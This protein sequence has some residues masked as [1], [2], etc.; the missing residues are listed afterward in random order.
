M[1][2]L[3]VDDEKMI[4]E[5]IKYTISTLS[6]EISIIDTASNG[7]EA[8]IKISQEYYDLIFIDIM[9]PKMNGIDML[10]NLNEQAIDSTL[11]VLS[12]HDEFKFAKEAIKYN[13]KE[14]LLKNECSKE[15]IS[16]LIFE[17]HEKL[18]NQQK[19]TSLTQEFLERVIKNNI[20][21]VGTDLINQNFPHCSSKTLFVAVLENKTEK[22]PQ[23]MEYKNVHIESEGLIGNIERVSFYLFSVME[24][25]APKN[26]DYSEILHQHLSVKVACGNLFSNTDK[27]LPECRNSWIG[28]Q[29]LFFTN[30]SHRTGSNRYREFDSE[31]ID[32]MC[33][34]TISD[35]RSYSKEK[36]TEDIK[37]INSFIKRTQPTDTESVVN[38]Y[39]TL[40]S[41]FI[42]YNNKK[43]RNLTEKL[44][45][46][47]T[48]IHS[49]EYFDQL[50]V[51]ILQIIENNTELI[52]R[53]K[54]S[55]VVEKALEYIEQNYKTIESISQIA[56]HVN[57]SLD[58]FSRQFKEEVGIT[59]NS[60][61]INF[62]LDQASLI[63]ISS[64]LSIQEVAE[65][66]GIEN[67]SY[68]S[69]CFKKK[70]HIQPVHFRIQTRSS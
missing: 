32:L 70:F 17:C 1:K 6:L 45:T 65:M 58:Y 54:F 69:K 3:I 44:E 11:I 38:T 40:L 18:L 61:L 59:L 66:V 19:L 62:R 8:L 53:N 10:K 39:F 46:L 4:R 64:D 49:F 31:K 50:A 37:E 51:W 30:A 42:I 35:I 21:A 25:E 24:N 20:P 34:K 16:E 22:I 23:S 12:S 56:D 55:Q 26:Y 36:M 43:S 57:L 9:M 48:K 52:Q 68:F 29:R 67:G 60:Y 47:V 41:T 28:Y 13:V 2:I 15:K 14:Y 5:W 63:L 27:L 7:E 33:D